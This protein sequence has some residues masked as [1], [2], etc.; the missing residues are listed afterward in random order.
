MSHLVS[1]A[2][3]SQKCSGHGSTRLLHGAEELPACLLQ[4]QDLHQPHKVV[5]SM[6][7]QTTCYQR[8]HIVL[9][10][11]ANV[12]SDLPLWVIRNIEFMGGAGGG[13]CQL[14]CNV[15]PS[16]QESGKLPR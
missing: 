1:D 6:V 4:A 2:A 7:R 10:D 5:C 15:E 13:M 16:T 9:I 11:P 14:T 8:I 12:L 3:L